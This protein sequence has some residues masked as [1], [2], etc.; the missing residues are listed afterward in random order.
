M[1]I[2]HTV[3]KSPFSNSAYHS[4]LRLAAPEDVILLLEDGVYGALTDMPAGQICA[5]KNDVQARGLLEKIPEKVV[6]VG[7]SEFV[8]MA[9][10][11]SAVQSWY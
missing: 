2:L 8:Q 1:M 6:L 4:C 9:C 7:Y 10:E 5:L 3:N 11:A